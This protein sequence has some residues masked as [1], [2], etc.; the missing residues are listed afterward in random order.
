[1]SSWHI[2]IS[3]FRVE[4]FDCILRHGLTS[5][6]AW[7]ATKTHLHLSHCLGTLV[8]LENSLIKRAW[9]LHWY[10]HHHLYAQLFQLSQSNLRWHALSKLFCL[11]TFTFP[12]PDTPWNCSS[13]FPS[14]KS[15]VLSSSCSLWSPETRSC[16]W[17]IFKT[18]LWFKFWQVKR[19]AHI[20]T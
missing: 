7:T 11:L 10:L 5:L 9:I 14:P 6:L 1:M 3:M 15:P 4:L 2:P 13:S 8:L 19:R 16:E 17:P 20:F 12:L 18:S